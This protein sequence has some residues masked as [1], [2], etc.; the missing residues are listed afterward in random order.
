M[1]ILSFYSPIGLLV[2]LGALL[3]S[4]ALYWKNMKTKI[5]P[6]ANMCSLLVFLVSLVFLINTLTQGLN[7]PAELARM[8]AAS[9]LMDLYAGICNVAARVWVRVLELMGTSG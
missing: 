4:C 7:D 5:V 1:S 2:F 3:I 9:I 6:I 8:L